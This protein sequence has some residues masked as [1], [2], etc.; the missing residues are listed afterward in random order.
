MVLRAEPLR[1]IF[2]NPARRVRWA[3]ALSGLMAAA[4][5]FTAPVYSL[6]LGAA[7]FGVPHVVSG[8]RHVLVHGRVGR[9]T[10]AGI[11]VGLGLGVAQIA[12]AGDWAMQAFALV[13][14]VS[15]AAEVVEAGGPRRRTALLLA[16]TAAGGTLAFAL[17]SLFALA[18]LH[19]HAW[20]SLAWFGLK[21]QRRGWVVWPVL[22][23]FALLALLVTVGALDFLL[24][25]ALLAPRAGGR[26]VLVE[27][28]SAAW[29]LAS[30]VVLRR[31]LVLYVFGQQLHFA[32]WLRLMPEVDRPSPVP[33]SF[34]RALATLRADLGP[35][36]VPA[37]AVAGLG[38]LGVLLG[39]GPARE[40]YFALTYFHL[41]LEAAALA[42]LAASAPVSALWEV[43]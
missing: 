7:L 20:T 38:A 5:A 43:A 16:L 6:W 14:A 19:L 24:P 21:A 3:L 30:G 35:W 12:G 42:R 40:G 34:S 26:S 37:L 1:A 22:A 32:T 8:L 31:A 25:H 18:F 9:M 17:P 15:I 23:A 28:S 10:R 36:A 29:P 41:G 13:F 27:A 2:V 33:H 11:W 4:W 39:G